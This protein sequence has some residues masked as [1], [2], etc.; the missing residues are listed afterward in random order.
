MGNS[1]MAHNFR[2]HLLNNF[3][4]DLTN[5]A[6]VSARFRWKCPPKKRGEGGE[7]VFGLWQLSQGP[8]GD[9]AK[10]PPGL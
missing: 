3:Y 8:S 10:I 9:L 5:A 4:Q 2:A 6:R 7:L 1:A